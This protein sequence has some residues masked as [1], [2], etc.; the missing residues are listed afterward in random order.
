MTGKAQSWEGAV[1]GRARRGLHHPCRSWHTQDAQTKQM[2]SG[3]LSFLCSCQDPSHTQLHR[4]PAVRHGHVFPRTQAEGGGW[5]WRVYGGEAALP[6]DTCSYKKL[7]PLPADQ[8]RAADVRTLPR[9]P[10]GEGKQGTPPPRGGAVGEQHGLG[11][12]KG[13]GPWAQPWEALC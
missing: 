5:Q 3:V 13:V 6:R 1:P 10:G 9:S 2:G 7:L 11:N 8:A 4:P 12:L